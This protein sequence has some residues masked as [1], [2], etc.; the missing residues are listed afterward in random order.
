MRRRGG[1]RP[2]G[3]GTDVFAV[4]QQHCLQLGDSRQR[5][6]MNLVVLGRQ[7]WDMGRDKSER[8]MQLAGVRV[9]RA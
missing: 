5:V 4:T 3:D 7:G 1:T 6:P 2:L 8:Q 9:V